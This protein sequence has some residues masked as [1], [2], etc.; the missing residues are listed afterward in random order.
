MDSK[1]EIMTNNMF[2][3]LFRVNQVNTKITGIRL[4]KKTYKKMSKLIRGIQDIGWIFLINKR[5]KLYEYH[6]QKKS[7]NI[8]NFLG[9][10][11]VSTV[12]ST[13]KLLR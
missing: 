11:D 13:T 1:I 8:D 2:N 9:I 12:N 7:R 5:M 3:D 6:I 10:S 4:S